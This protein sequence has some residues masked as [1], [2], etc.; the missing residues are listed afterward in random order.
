MKMQR[1]PFFKVKGL[2]LLEKNFRC[3]KGEIDLILMDGACL[4][5]TEVKYRSGPGCGSPLE[6]IDGRKQKKIRHTAAYYMYIRRISQDTPCR[7]DAEVLWENQFSGYRML[8]KRI[9]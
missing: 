3:R 2:R 9:D 8:F 1:L 5:F 7:F 6:A 4:V